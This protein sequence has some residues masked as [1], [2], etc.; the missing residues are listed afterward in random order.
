MAFVSGATTAR[1][2]AYCG[3]RPRGRAGSTSRAFDPSRRWAFTRLR[4]TCPS[5]SGRRLSPGRTIPRSNDFASASSGHRPSRWTARQRRQHQRRGRYGRY[6]RPATRR[7][8]LTARRFILRSG[9]R[10]TSA[11]GSVMTNG[12]TPTPPVSSQR[13]MERS[14]SMI[15]RISHRLP[16]RGSSTKD[17][18]PAR[19]RKVLPLCPTL[20]Y[21][22]PHSPL[23]RSKL[24]CMSS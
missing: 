1:S 15:P 21:T 17:R 3:F 4:R 20:Q 11:R 22:H 18:P 10:S 2:K 6:S 19:V 8:G 12:R 16:S 7:S 24:A 14:T 5:I 13:P 23:G 9:R